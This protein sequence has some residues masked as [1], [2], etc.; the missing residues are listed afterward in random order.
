MGRTLLG[1]QVAEYRAKPITNHQT[2]QQQQQP[3]IFQT[4]SIIDGGQQQNAKIISVISFIGQSMETLKRFG[5]QL[6]IQLDTNMTQ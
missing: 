2:E 6:K 5:E 1:F 4:A 3:K